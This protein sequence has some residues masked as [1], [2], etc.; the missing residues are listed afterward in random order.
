MG[1]LGGCDSRS[2]VSGKKPALKLSRPVEELG[3]DE[4][5]VRGQMRLD[6]GLPVVLVVGTSEAG[7]RTSEGPNQ[8][9]LRLAIVGHQTK[10]CLCDE[11]EAILRL[12]LHLGEWIAN[13]KVIGDQHVPAVSGKRQVSG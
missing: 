13:R 7:G 11:S 5:G 3:N 6:L 10:A 1:V 8:T 12:R 2:V 4:A 9:Q